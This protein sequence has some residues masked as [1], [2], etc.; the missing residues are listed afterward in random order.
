MTTAEDVRGT[1]FK[2]KALSFNLNR[3]ISSN[4]MQRE[5]TA[6]DDSTYLE[7]YFCKEISC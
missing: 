4:A 5:N 3:F 6:G 1:Y 2:N 7:L